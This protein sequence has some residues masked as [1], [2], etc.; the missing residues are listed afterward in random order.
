MTF[1]FVGLQKHKKRVLPDSSKMIILHCSTQLSIFHAEHC[2]LHTFWTIQIH[3][4][5]KM[6]EWQCVYHSL[7]ISSVYLGGWESN[8]GT[9]YT[10]KSRFAPNLHNTTYVLHRAYSAQ[11]RNK[12]TLCLTQLKKSFQIYYHFYVFDLYLIVR[13]I[14]SLKVALE[15]SYD[16]FIGTNWV[17]QSQTLLDPQSDGPM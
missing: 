17:L 13:Q 4:V 15:T 10:F 2:N 6:I 14:F 7:M 3:Y 9:I 12:R 11:V 8:T 16:D 5:I 1:L